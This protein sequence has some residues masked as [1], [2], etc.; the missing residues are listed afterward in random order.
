[1]R[2][3]KVPTRKAMPPAVSGVPGDRDTDTNMSTTKISQ[4][5]TCCQ[6]VLEDPGIIKRRVIFHHDAHPTG[7]ESTCGSGESLGAS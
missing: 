6:R 4:K 1:M 5:I 7:S 3:N 2:T